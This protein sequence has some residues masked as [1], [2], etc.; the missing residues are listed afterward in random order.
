MTATTY[1][2]TP[3]VGQ[4]QSFVQFNSTVSALNTAIQAAFASAAG[5]IVVQAD[6]VSGQTSNA[7]IIVNDSV[8]FSVPPNNW[9]GYNNG[10]W[11]QWTPAQMNGGSNSVFTQ[12]FTS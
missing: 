10:A 7:V 12:Y 3:L 1:L 9:V 11:S 5:T 6:T 4:V 8:V 2:P